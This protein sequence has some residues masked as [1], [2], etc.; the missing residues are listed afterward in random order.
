MLPKLTMLNIAMKCR[1]SQLVALFSLT[2]AASAQLSHN[3]ELAFY[4]LVDPGDR[5]SQAMAP[6]T[7]LRFG[8][9]APAG[10]GSSS[11]PVVEGVLTVSTAE[12]LTLV[13]WAAP[14]A[15]GGFANLASVGEG[16][17]PV[18]IA[19]GWNEVVNGLGRTNFSMTDDRTTSYQAIA[20]LQSYG[21]VVP[22]PEP[23]TY[24]AL[25][26]LFLFAGGHL[27]K[28]RRERK[29]KQVQAA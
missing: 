5:V 21:G 13:Y 4:T 2:A 6:Q 10:S 26:M 15:S 18:S 8:D 23:S 22:V 25:G 14:D 27:W 29:T 3:N 28:S 24:L 12:I 17:Q 20:R 7:A 11:A 19:Y 9:V 1:L 16:N